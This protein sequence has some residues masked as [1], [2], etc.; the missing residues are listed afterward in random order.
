MLI[1]IPGTCRPAL[2]LV[3]IAKVLNFLHYRLK[4]VADKI[5]KYGYTTPQALA[6]IKNCVVK[7]CVVGPNHIAFLL[8]VNI[9]VNCLHIKV[10]LYVNYLSLKFFVYEGWPHVPSA[11]VYFDR[12]ARFE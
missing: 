4:E 3:V 6:N 1:N 11:I 7:Q 10:N 9:F 8:E 5:N 2:F 12:K